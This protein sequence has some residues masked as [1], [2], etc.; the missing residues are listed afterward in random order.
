M[1]EIQ[2]FQGNQATEF[3]TIKAF[4]SEKNIYLISLFFTSTDANTYSITIY[5]RPL[6]PGLL[7]T[8]INQE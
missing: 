2:T 1:Y 8:K 7:V 6:Y 3:D 4:Q 5:S